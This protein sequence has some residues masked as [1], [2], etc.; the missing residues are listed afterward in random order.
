MTCDIKKGQGVTINGSNLIYGGA[1]QSFSMTP[2]A[3]SGQ[4]RAN[5]T[6]IGSSINE[7]SVGAGSRPP[8]VS[9][10]VLGSAFQMQLAGYTIKQ[11][12]NSPT[13]LSLD[14]R[15]TSN[16]ALDSKFI[17]LE[18][19][20]PDGAIPQSL[21]VLG[22]KMGPLPNAELSD[23]GIITANRDTKYVNIL[24]FFEK[25]TD[26]FCGS[27]KAR[28]KANTKSSP[29]KVLYLASELK[30]AISGI[31]GNGTDFPQKSMSAKGS[32][33][34]VLVSYAN[35][36]GLQA[37]WD[38]TTE[39][40]ILKK[41]SSPASGFAKMSAIASQCAA[42]SSSKTVDYTTTFSNGAVGSI[43]SSF[44]GEN[45]STAGMKISKYLT[46]TLLQPEF[47]YV[48]CKDKASGKLTLLNFADDDILK[49]ITAAGNQE[50]YAAYAL[51]S[52]IP[53]EA[54][55][56][57]VNGILASKMPTLIVPEGGF[58]A[59]EMTIPLNWGK[60]LPPSKAGLEKYYTTN[61]FLGDYY[62]VDPSDPL[63]RECAAVLK[64]CMLGNQAPLGG[65]KGVMLA[66]DAL[67][68]ATGIA[69]DGAAPAPIA[70]AAAAVPN[71]EPPNKGWNTNLQEDPCK[72]M[73]EF[74]DGGEFAN[75][76]M[77]LQLNPYFDSVM[78]DSGLDSSTDILRQYLLAIQAFRNKF[79]V[80][81]EE[82]GNC[83][84]Q[85]VKVKGK[86]YGYY[87]SSEAQNSP[88]SVKAPEGYKLITVNPFSSLGQCGCTEIKAL[89]TVL[90]CMY[91]PKGK[92]LYE[93][94]GLAPDPTN[95][96]KL[97]RG[98]AGISVIDF[99]YAME[100]SNGPSE[101]DRGGQQVSSNLENLF[102]GMV[103]GGRAVP[104]GQRYSQDKDEPQLTMFLL[105]MDSIEEDLGNN[106]VFSF[107]GNADQRERGGNMGQL[108][109]AAQSDGPAL[110]L[111]K[112]MIIDLD[113]SVG[114]IEPLRQVLSKGAGKEGEQLTLWGLKVKSSGGKTL[115]LNGNIPTGYLETD[116]GDPF[117]GSA[118]LPAAS[119]TPAGPSIIKVWYDVTNTPNSS[120]SSPSEF[121]I[122]GINQF[123]DSNAWTQKINFGISLNAADLGTPDNKDFR[124]SELNITS[125]WGTNSKNQG[126]SYSSGN[127][128][129]MAKFL[130]SKLKNSS[131]Q[132][133]VPGVSSTVSFV[134]FQ[135][136]PSLPS[137][138]EGLESLSISINGPITEITAT[139][140]NAI[141]KNSI[142][143]MYSRISQ[144]PST[145][146]KPMSI[147][148]DSFQLGTTARFSQL[149]K[150]L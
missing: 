34:E 62:G 108:Q 99:I 144:F 60:L 55:G 27:P 150:G 148:P 75:G 113:S 87:I 40:V 112:E 86:S 117:A 79:Y 8:R 125:P 131:E 22:T 58:L 45:Q 1:I 126:N 51:Q 142:K 124:E 120:N 54:G 11:S 2:S 101:P 128:E 30:E 107:L 67:S 121:T 135:G 9:V 81:K 46:A 118:F 33:R 32:I 38:M 91:L 7:P 72:T 92:S 145:Q 16:I 64:G 95:P 12:A 61:K 63:S 123:P 105:T 89:A 23:N 41:A 48:K 85:S 49:A 100:S 44:Q 59:E 133:L 134:A 36:T 26:W 136:M 28:M 130:K 78:T 73:G 21:I 111:A 3:L 6:V 132:D 90:A 29:G 103:G 15:D 97:A 137:M 77:F 31:L 42:I 39:K 96:T 14:L 47:K 52:S 147:I 98:A 70:G 94:M 50:V 13:T 109:N 68:K 80:I 149:M 24:N 129:L 65:L 5:V 88:M 84:G 102:K 83:A 71:K 114:A 106:P 139:V 69:V 57:M 119:L 10:Q 115:D 116:T 104:V 56:A 37:W 19:D 43:T 141:Y 17:V 53:A 143:Q 20:Q 35:D 82:R 146:Y 110:K 93:V 138:A 122:A 4:S 18:G 25:S 127:R 74:E 66:G 140:G 76:P